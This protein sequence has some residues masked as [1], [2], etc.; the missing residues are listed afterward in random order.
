MRRLDEIAY[1]IVAILVL[2]VCGTVGYVYIEGYRPMEALY[3]TVGVL[4]TLGLQVR[5]SL[6]PQGQALTIALVVLGI[7]VVLYTLVLIAQQAI[8][9]ELRAI[10]GR[11]RMERAIDAMQ[12]HVIVCGFG[13]IGRIVC[14]ELR[15]KP[16]PF[17]VVESDET[18]VREIDRDEYLGVHGD[19]TAEESLQRAGIARAS[20]LVAVLPSDAENVFVTLTA[21]ALQP[22][23]VVVARAE[24]ET[25]A[26]RLAQAGATRVVSP[27]TIGGHRMAQAIL[28]PAVLDFVDLAAHHLSLELQLEEI[29]IT[30]AVA[31]PLASSGVRD[32]VDVMVVA[33]YKAD[34]SVRFNPTPDELVVRGD[35]LLAVG[36]AHSLKALEQQLGAQR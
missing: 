20:A 8:G 28:R 13:R 34:G 11:R 32:H 26:A 16:A 12:D 22:T 29:P 5:P 9:G 35:R 18:V 25:G 1:G 27:Y 24:T 36:A 21:R 3:V 4:S 14:R 10:L 30:R 2:T 15:A 19:A 17:V 31:S 6:S 23:L 33:I 7:G